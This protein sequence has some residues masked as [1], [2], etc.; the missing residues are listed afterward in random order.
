MSIQTDQQLFSTDRA[1]SSIGRYGLRKVLGTGPS[2]TV[3][4]AFDPE[5]GRDVA[6]NLMLAGGG[7]AEA[8]A[9]LTREAE[10][11]ASIEHPHLHKVHEVG[12]YADP[13]ERSRQGVY[14][15]REL[16]S[17]MD[18]QRWLDALTRPIAM[19]WS[20]LLGMFTDAGSALAAAHLRGLVHGGFSP[21]SMMVSYDGT[22][23]VTDFAS[24]LAQPLGEAD[25]FASV[26][27]AA[28]E[29]Q[30]GARAGALSDQYSF[31]AAAWTSLQRVKQGKM[32]KR[33]DA[34][35][36]RGMADDPAD[37]WPSMDALLAALGRARRGVLRRT[38]GAFSGATAVTVIAAAAWTALA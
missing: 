13:R 17:G 20:Q 30:N 27:Y 11:W 36:A 5:T 18:M 21:A 24:D 10:L 32:P 7:D 34:I 8:L 35:L 1:L 31:C 12:T 15:V 22:V 33:V 3:Y 38:L 19:S 29:V 4:A 16:V 28:P 23:T 2:G 25:P 9:A 6:I 14:V 37:R 26:A